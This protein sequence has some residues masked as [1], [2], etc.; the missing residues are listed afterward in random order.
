MIDGRNIITADKGIIDALSSKSVDVLKIETGYVLLDGFEYGFIGG[1]TGRA[2]EYMMFNGDLSVHPDSEAVRQFVNE[3]GIEVFEV[4][5]KPL[6]D[7]G[8]IIAE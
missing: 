5:G 7:I 3:R 4:K 1:A 2:G 6:Y 8:T